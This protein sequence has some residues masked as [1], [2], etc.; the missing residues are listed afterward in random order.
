MVLEAARAENHTAQLTMV[1]A[2]GDGIAGLCTG[3]ETATN[4]LY[5][6]RSNPLAPRGTLLA[7]EP[8]DDHTSWEPIT[9]HDDFELIYP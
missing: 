1:L 6:A 8:L 9:S 2:G 5:L 3:S 7:S 4:S